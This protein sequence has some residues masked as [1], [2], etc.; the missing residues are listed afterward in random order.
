MTSYT[1]FALF[2]DDLTRNIDYGARARYFAELL[3]RHSRRDPQT[4]LDLACGTGSLSYRFSAMG[5]DVIGVDSSS[6]MLS[7][8]AAKGAGAERAPLFICQDMR[9][10]DLYGTV[11]A[12]VCALDSINHLPDKPAL[13]KAAAK[14]SL[15]LAPGG[16]FIFDVNT[17]YK[18][19]ELL[20]NNVYVYDLDTVYCVWRN[21]YRPKDGQ[22]EI[23]LDFFRPGK[24][25]GYTRTGEYFT[26]RLFST[27][28]IKSALDGAGL[29]LLAVYG[30]D[31]FEPPGKKSQRA[32]YVA[33]KPI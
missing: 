21:A 28:Q 13:D 31:G 1:S 7:A 6:D 24:G 22:V 32:V 9:E 33:G 25:G 26:E 29:E 16:V 23:T 30:G 12:C 2:Y 18:H 10:L 4:L 17:G 8:A 11:D 14:V 5:Y 3:R 20:G 27:G 19:R 15:F